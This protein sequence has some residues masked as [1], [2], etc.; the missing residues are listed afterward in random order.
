[1]FERLSPEQH[2][3]LPEVPE[4]AENPDFHGHETI[5]RQIVSA[6]RDGKLHHALLLGGPQGIGKAT[7]AFHLA[8]HLL[9]FSDPA[10]APDELTTADPQS[11]L[12]RQM[13][14]GAHPAVLYLTR[15][16]GAKD[17][18]F[19]TEITVGEIRRVNKFLAMTS[20]DRSNRVVIVDPVD[21]LNRNAANALLKNLE[22]P[23]SRTFFLLIAHS[24]GR[25]LKTIVSRC[26][27]IRFSPLDAKTLLDVLDALPLETPDNP[28]TRA[29][30][31]EHAR[32]SVRKAVLLTQFGGFEISKAADEVL[33]SRAFNPR[34]AHEVA[35]AIGGRDQKIQFDIFNQ[36]LLD[37]LA[38]TARRQAESGNATD[39]DRTGALWQETSQNILETEIYNLDRKQ[40]VVSLLHRLN[41][42]LQTG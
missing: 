10:G 42:A 40:H 28:E 2:D 37:R 20:H 9:K 29:A 18:T 24:P 22:E 33:N 39:A 27:S 23:P 7:F 16:R 35:S 34:K 5:A 14:T 15:P 12:S 4:P 38:T 36:H 17:G 11:S 41:R 13:A 6:Y 3:T 19:K 25:I 26:L 30:L 21:D 8:R 1:M 31:A 32:G